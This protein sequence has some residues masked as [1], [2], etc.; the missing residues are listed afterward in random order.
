MLH[1]LSC[2]EQYVTFEQQN[3]SNLDDFFQFDLSGSRY[4]YLIEDEIWN[5][6]PMS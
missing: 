6:V 1:F 3:C 5:R 2:C 4:I